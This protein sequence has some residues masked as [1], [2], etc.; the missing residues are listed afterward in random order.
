[1]QKTSEDE[2]T[3]DRGAGL[4]VGSLSQVNYESGKFVQLSY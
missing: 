2:V 3:N 4:L 1:M